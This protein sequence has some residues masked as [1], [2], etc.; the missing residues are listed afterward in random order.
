[1]PAVAA[2]T[3]SV[4]LD[5]E[6]RDRIKRLAE[7]RYRTP[8]WVMREAIREYIEREEKREAFRQATFKAWEEYRETGMHVTGDEVTAWLET[9]GEA[10]EQAA[11][12]C[13]K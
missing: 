5:G 2:R 1:M 11:P 4:K 3:L 12:A 10:Q 9:W 13:H 8:H 6:M 7:A